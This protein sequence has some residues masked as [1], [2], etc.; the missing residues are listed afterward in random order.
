MNY[1]LQKI[2]QETQDTGETEDGEK[3]WHHLTAYQIYTRSFCDSNGDG[4]EI[5]R[6]LS[7]SWIIF[8]NW[9]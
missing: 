1:A 5:F 4:I 2:S 6:E 8:R 3:W 7:V 9:G